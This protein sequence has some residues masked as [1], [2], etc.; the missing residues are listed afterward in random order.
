MRTLKMLALGLGML[1]FSGVALRA[2]NTL[3]LTSFNY[4]ISFNNTD[5]GGG[6]LAGATLNGVALPWVYCVQLGVTVTVPG[7]YQDT[8]VDNTGV[9]HNTNP[10][11]T[12]PQAQEIAW[13]LSTYANG[14]ANTT[15]QE[16]LQGAIWHVEGFGNLTMSGAVQTDYLSMISGVGTGDVSQY[17]WMTPG[18]SATDH[19]YQGLVT[20][21]DGGVTLM[22]LGGALVGLETLRRRFRV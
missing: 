9:I 22:L 2:D 11:P 3:I 21:P 4:P 5:Y 14:A 8:I 19:Q 6:S 16:A 13:L 1:A 12:L 15:L 18:H 7:I 20:V 17:V 10:F